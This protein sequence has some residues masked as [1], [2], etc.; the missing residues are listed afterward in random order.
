MRRIAL[1]LATVGVIAAGLAAGPAQAHAGWGDYRWQHQEW[2]EHA[3][4]DREWREHRERHRLPAIIAGL[5]HH[6]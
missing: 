5:L 6:R 3:W 4:R 2:R 1:V